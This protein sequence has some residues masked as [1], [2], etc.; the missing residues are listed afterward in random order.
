MFRRNGSIK[1]RSPLKA[2]LCMCDALMAFLKILWQSFLLKNQPHVW[3]KQQWLWGT[4]LMVNEAF[5]HRFLWAVNYSQWNSGA[6]VRQDLLT[7]TGHCNLEEIEFWF[8]SSLFIHS[9]CLR[10]IGYFTLSSLGEC[11]VEFIFPLYFCFISSIL[12]AQ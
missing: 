8:L 1:S 4:D 7:L 5:W 10:I 9:R 6:S 11:Y 12:F 2:Q 3:K